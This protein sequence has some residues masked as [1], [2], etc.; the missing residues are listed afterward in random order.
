M[1]SVAILLAAAPMAAPNLAAA[2]D[3][4]AAGRVEQARQMAAEA[5]A[6]GASGEALDRLLADLAAAQQ[7]H[8]EALGRY[9]ALV[10]TSPDDGA[11]LERAASTA[12]QLNERARAEDLARRATGLSG[13]GWKAWNILAMGAD[14]QRDWDAADRAYGKALAL[15]PDQPE[16][17]NNLGWS[18]LLRGQWARAIPYL[19]RAHRRAPNLARARDNLELARAAL[20]EKLPARRPG[21]SA[22]E[23][24]VR[25]NDAGVAAALR[26]ERERAIAAFSQ[27]LE[28]EPR[29]FARASNNL[30]NL[31]G[32]GCS[33]RPAR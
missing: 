22:S 31:C 23:W 11:L 16:L 25:L 2:H 3:A 32:T 5:V 29:W 26:G 10:E 30:A 7:R 24:A 21:E 4:L 15:A 28:A 33:L 14:R 17:L 6:G 12:W 18:H 27:A 1:L 8:E 9:L 13:S 19:E 20:A